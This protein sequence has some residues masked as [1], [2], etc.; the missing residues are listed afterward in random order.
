MNLCVW[1]ACVVRDRND[2]EGKIRFGAS[3]I[4]A[5]QIED[6]CQICDLKDQF[7]KGSKEPAWK[8]FAKHA[9]GKCS[10]GSDCFLCSRRTKTKSSSSHQETTRPTSSTASQGNSLDS[11]LRRCSN[12]ESVET[13]QEKGEGSVRDQTT[14]AAPSDPISLGSV[15]DQ[16]KTRVNSALDYL[17]FGDI[18]EEEF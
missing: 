5:I 11:T 6:S 2:L 15:V 7:D 10:G 1:C 13:K 8:A 9:D 4:E 3:F 12:T 14:A 18:D 17:L 16:V